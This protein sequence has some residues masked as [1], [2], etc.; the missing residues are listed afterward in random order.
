VNITESHEWMEAATDPD[1]NSPISG[2]KLGWY[3]DKLGEIGDL[4]IRQ[5]PLNQTFE[6]VDGFK[7]QKE[8]SNLDGKFE[9][10][11]SDLNSP[12]VPPIGAKVFG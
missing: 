7:V 3:N 5:L 12:V 1:V 4:A 6:T 2:R 10:V 9:T 8:W 11:E